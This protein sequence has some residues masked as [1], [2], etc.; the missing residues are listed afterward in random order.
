MQRRIKHKEPGKKLPSGFKLFRTA[1]G[2]LRRHWKLFGGILLAYAALDLV[3][4]QGISSSSDLVTTK[5]S[6][7]ALFQGSWGHLAS[8]ASVFLYLLGSQGSNI[9]G[10]AAYQLV[11]GL[12]VS[13]AVI[14]AL[15]EVYAGRKIRIRD[16]Y[17]RGMYPL[18]PF[19]GVLVVLLLQC[20]PLAF[21]AYV[22]SV[23]SANSIATT[24]I[25]HVL[26][27]VL[28]AGLAAVTLYMVCASLF[29]VYIVCLPDMAPFQALRTARSLVKGRRLAILRRLVFLPVIVLVL[30]AL[31]M[32]PI[33]LFA[34]AAAPWLF[35]LC[36]VVLVA[37]VHSYM[38]ALYRSLI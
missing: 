20:I 5:H 25:E 38:Y 16:A 33:V 8:G 29:A 37:V 15:R 10:G 3:L 1:I 17:Y 6:I 18:V 35:Y 19:A 14:W 12:A 36:S 24:A 4:V 34:T 30:A 22:Y 7:D 23:V 13:L 11:L 21:G 26:W 9:T 2:T 27:V 28:F 31:I 32:I